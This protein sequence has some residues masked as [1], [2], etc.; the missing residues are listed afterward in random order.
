M[1]FTRYYFLECLRILAT[2]HWTSAATVPLAGLVE[3]V[4]P[5]PQHCFDD[6]NVSPF[7][8]SLPVD[9]DQCGGGFMTGTKEVDAFTTCCDFLSEL[10][11]LPLIL[12]HRAKLHGTGVCDRALL[13]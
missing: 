5:G 1:L 10:K 9:K 8:W 12:Q 3:I 11:R 6:C 2:D 7:L 13:A 4:G